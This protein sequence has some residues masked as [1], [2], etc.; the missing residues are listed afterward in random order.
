ME[1]TSIGVPETGMAVKICYFRP[2]FRY[3]SETMHDSNIV[4]IER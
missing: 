4:T 2:I 1:L 3:F